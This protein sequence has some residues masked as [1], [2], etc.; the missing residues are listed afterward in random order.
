M[1]P[2]ARIALILAACLAGVAALPRTSTAQES[3]GSPD[4]R[5]LSEVRAQQQR[6]ERVRRN[7][8][9]WTRGRDGGGCDE[10]IGR[11]CLSHGSG[12]A[13]WEPE[14]EHPRVV[15]ARD[16]LLQALGA[17]A[18]RFPGSGWVA[19]QRV[20]YL[21]E[22][23]RHEDAVR[24]A[25]DCDAAVWWCAALTGFAM[26]YA[27]M[28]ADADSAFSSAL[29][30]M[31]EPEL[32]RWTDLSPL[33]DDCAIR[34]YRRLPDAA[35][36]AFED[37][38][39]RLADPFATLPGNETRSEHLARHVW[40]GLQERAASTEGLS[41]ADDLREILLRYGWPR[42]WERVRPDS[43]AL[44]PASMVSHYAGSDRDLL[45]PC[46][47][48][49][50]GN[51]TAGEWDLEPAQP[52]T[53]Y[54]IPMP[55]S[56]IEWVGGV[57]FQVATFRRGDSARVVAA[58]EIP[59]DS[60]RADASVAA[61]VALLTP[62][63]EDAG[64]TSFPRG[65]HSDV[66]AVPAP[67]GP[68]LLT[69]EMLAVEARRAARV[70]YGIDVARAAPGLIGISDL[71]L[72]SSTELLPE[73]LED[74]VRSARRSTRVA[75]GERVGVYWEIYGLTAP[76]GDD[77]A[78]ALR[79]VRAD[80]GWLRGIGRA[81]GLVDDAPPVLVRWREA[82]G[83]R[84]VFARAVAVTIPPEIRPGRY[85]LELTVTAAGRE[86]L[87]IRRLISVAQP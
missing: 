61:A 69:I 56:V 3:A 86:P 64:I 85:A 77:L 44:G 62:G 27:G 21:V 59:T 75:P 58:Y 12:D 45:P 51:L 8:L 60:L 6:F 29:A 49:R 22:A 18:A 83:A 2:T 34:H 7:H 40:D 14:P 28:P 48:V 38:F 25:G 81:I 78:L 80:G 1:K 82:P 15:A 26:H 35:R 74:A 19:G 36:H 13:D 31:P 71:L 65:G 50:D 79:V 41:W 5:L 52:R 70:R 46:E 16:E 57:D 68:M 30:V 73:S 43:W 39:W 10:R 84:D 11:F 54:A 67:Q 55:D 37:R 47:V 76:D 24:A 87:T 4:P 32:L 20:R 42:G 9:P 72:L 66:L 23:G 17:A 53:G 33:L 63:L